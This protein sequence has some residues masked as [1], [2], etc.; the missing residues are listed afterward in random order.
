MAL[1]VIAYFGG[2]SY[3]RAG[4]LVGRSDEAVREWYKR[5]GP[6]FKPTKKRRRRVAVDEKV[7]HAPDGDLYLWA[8]VDIDTNEIL[9]VAVTQGRS[10]LEAKSFLAKALR[11]CRG[12][13]PRFFVDAAGWYASAL[14]SLELKFAVMHWG[15]RSAVERVFAWV[16]RRLKRFWSRFPFRSSLGSV[17]SWFGALFGLK[18]AKM[19]LS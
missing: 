4:E 11:Y 7:I 2:L 19:T 14:G 6:L 13:T 12:R 8:A 17:R 18:T 5:T 3:D 9:A 1:A 15:P 16:E 10:H